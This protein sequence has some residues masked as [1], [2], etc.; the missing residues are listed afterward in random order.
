LFI[1]A[2][3]ISEHKMIVRNSEKKIIFFIKFYDRTCI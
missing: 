1:W 3:E 2:A